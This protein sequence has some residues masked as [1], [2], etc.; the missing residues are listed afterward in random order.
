MSMNEQYEWVEDGT[1]A[2][3]EPAFRL[4]LLQG[5]QIHGKSVRAGLSNFR[6]DQNCDFVNSWINMEGEVR[7]AMLHGTIIGSAN[8]SKGEKTRILNSILHSC[9]IS[10][11]QIVLSCVDFN[12]VRTMRLLHFFGATGSTDKTLVLSQITYD[13]SVRMFNGTYSEFLAIANKE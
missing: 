4:R 7:N 9:M 13:T 8:P 1:F 10:A 11:K 3:G 12:D 6:V 5:F 2:D